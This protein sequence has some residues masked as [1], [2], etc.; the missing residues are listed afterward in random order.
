[1]SQRKHL[2][3]VLDLGG[4][5]FRIALANDEG[6]LLRRY[7]EPLDA[8]DKPEQTIGQMKN[9]IKEMLSGIDLELL[10]GMG[11]AVAGLVKPTDGVLLTSPNLLDWYNTPMKD[12]WEQEL[13]LPVWVCNDA[14]L[15]ALGE[16][17]F[18]AGRGIDDLIY[19]TV[20]TGI[21][22]GVI[23]GGKLLLGASGFAAEV[24]HMTIDLNGPGCSCGNVG[25]LEMLASG[26]AIARFAVEKISRGELSTITD[27]VTGDLGKVTAE[28][29]A[30]AARSGDLVAREVMHTAGANLG[31]GVVNL[32][33][34]FNPELVIIGGGCS[35]AGDLIFEPVRQVVDERTMPD[36]SVRIVPTA[37]GDAPGLLGAVAL[38]LENTSI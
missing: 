20:S 9:A 22:G 8:P 19:I 3:L 31:I 13:H 26:T 37:L 21:G 10:R 27:L 12:I 1:L 4:T 36:I 38:V 6:E 30:E 33:H 16:H 34:I 35:K 18:G 23:T 32:V 29:V 14:D 24:G 5:Q 28:T 2:I 11:V 7:A 15:A 17:R 25:C